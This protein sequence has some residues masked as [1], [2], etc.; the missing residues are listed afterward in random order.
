MYCSIDDIKKRIPET[1]LAQITD[2]VDGITVDENTVNKAIS[3]A[4][5]LIDSHLRG[6]YTSLPLSP[7]PTIINSVAVDICIYDLH[8]RRITD[9][10]PEAIK[11]RYKNAVKVL[12]NIRDGKLSIGVEPGKEPVNGEYRINKT[13][14]DRIFSK[15]KLD[16][17]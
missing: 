17:Y 14:E 6:R 12:E 1:V 4:Q 15:S 9:E 16:T 2:D 5:S 13:S 10:L 8:S 11:D 3:D 7:T